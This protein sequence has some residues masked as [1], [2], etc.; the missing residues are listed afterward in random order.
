MIKLTQKQADEIERVKRIGFP[1]RWKDNGW[2]IERDEAL[3]GLSF[4]Q[5]INAVLKDYE[6]EPEFKVGDWVV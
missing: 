3:N 4:Y 5:Y 6:V 2:Y 1:T